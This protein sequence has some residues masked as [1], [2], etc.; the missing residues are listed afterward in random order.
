AQ[1]L[2]TTRI[3]LDGDTPVRVLDAALANDWTLEHVDL[4]GTKD[5]HAIALAGMRAHCTGA[6]DLARGPFFRHTLYRIAPDHY[7]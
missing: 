7:Y 1:T 3:V 5:A 4:A 2:H 6:I